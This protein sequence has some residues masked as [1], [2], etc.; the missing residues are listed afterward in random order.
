MLRI[1]SLNVCIISSWYCTLHSQILEYPRLNNYSPSHNYRNFQENTRYF[2]MRPKK[3]HE[4]VKYC[5][6]DEYLCNCA[7]VLEHTKT[8][9]YYFLI[10]RT[11]SLWFQWSHCIP[12]YRKK[13][14]QIDSWLLDSWISN[15]PRFHT[16][17]T[18]SFLELSIFWTIL[19]Y[20]F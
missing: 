6:W 14:I 11:F 19:E 7:Q 17:A 5:R 2:P 1:V 8:F 10:N 3:S 13:S 12:V 15:K 9:L 20:K 18:D 16:S 4:E